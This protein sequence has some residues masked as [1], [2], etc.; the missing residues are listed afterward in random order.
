MYVDFNKLPKNARVWIFQSTR[1][2]TDEEILKIEIYLKQ[3]VENWK[4]HGKNVTGSFVIKYNQ[5]IVIALDNNERNVPGC[6]T[7]TSIRVL[8]VIEQEFEVDLL[9]K[10]NTAYR[11]NGFINSVK[12]IEFQ[13]LAKES[14]VFTDTIVFNGMVS[15]IQEFEALWEVPA[16]QSWHLRYFN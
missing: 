15:S 16:I 7:D 4:D 13:Q 6:V 9:N 1:R 2:F 10:F 14:K 3:F 5:F 11:E 12:L 8:R